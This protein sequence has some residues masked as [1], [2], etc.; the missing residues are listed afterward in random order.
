[1]GKKQARKAFWLDTEGVTAK[2]DFVPT[3]HF[4]DF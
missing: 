1:M 3:V 2:Q 4:I